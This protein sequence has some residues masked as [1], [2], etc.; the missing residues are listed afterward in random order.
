MKDE[1]NNLHNKVHP[2]EEKEEEKTKV[3]DSNI[4]I[5]GWAT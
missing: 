4:C 2:K 1:T 5:V 3:E